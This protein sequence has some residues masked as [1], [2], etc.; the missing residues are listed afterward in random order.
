MGVLFDAHCWFDALVCMA[1]RA[2]PCENVF[3]SDGWTISF[4][5]RGVH[6]TL[7]INSCNANIGLDEYH[8]LCGRK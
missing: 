7:C 8:T 5:A 2:S 6:T 1:L 3:D 4:D